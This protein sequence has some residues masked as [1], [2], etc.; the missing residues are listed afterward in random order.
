MRY[1]GA[2]HDW[3]YVYLDKL[4]KLEKRGKGIDG[5]TQRYVVIRTVI[6]NDKDRVVA[7]KL[8]KSVS[9]IGNI[10][11][12]AFEN[13]RILMENSLPALRYSQDDDLDFR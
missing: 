9:S 10:R 12:R 6:F 11:R 3:L 4:S 13:L 5:K 1:E 8:G 2:N 7:K